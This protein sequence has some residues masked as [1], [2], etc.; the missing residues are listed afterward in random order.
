MAN[1]TASIYNQITTAVTNEPGLAG[2]TPQPDSY[3]QLQ[4]DLSTTSKV[5]RWRW[6]ALSVAYVIKL[7]R[8]QFDLHERTVKELALEGHFGTRR[9][10]AAKARAWQY[11]HVLQFSSLDAYYLVDDPSARIV[12]QVAVV[13]VGNRVFVKAAKAAG[14]GLA[15]L[16][17]PERQ[18][19]DDYFQELRPPVY[20]T[21]ISADADKLRLSGTVVYD[22]QAI[23]L[24]VQAGVDAAV[25]TYLQTL[26]FGGVLRLTDLKA[27][28]LAVTGVVDVQFSLVEARST[29]AWATISRIYHSYAGH[30][31]I[32]AASPITTSMAWQ[33]GNV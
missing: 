22:A 13:E 16:D 15:K 17:P 11:G 27:A 31:A 3:L 23:L 32:D 24:G 21:V 8:D 10:F 26:E 30:M 19:L 14:T 1:S 2:L 33:A 25:R 12:A 28:M 5:S 6:I 9:W 20:V 4:S 7:L 29:G 18:A